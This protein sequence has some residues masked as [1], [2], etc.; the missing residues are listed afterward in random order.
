MILSF[1]VG[2]LGGDFV[3]ET[4]LT[5]NEYRR[6]EF[7]LDPREGILEMEVIGPKTLRRLEKKLIACR[8]NSVGLRLKEMVKSRRILETCTTPYSYMASAD[9]VHLSSAIRAK[10]KLTYRCISS[11]TLQLIPTFEITR[12]HLMNPHFAC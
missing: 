4:L 8:F 7:L 6:E 12:R 10:Q 3:R 1:T 2:E 5:I 9:F 11:R